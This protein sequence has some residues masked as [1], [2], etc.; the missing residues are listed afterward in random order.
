MTTQLTKQRTVPKLGRYIIDTSRSSVAFKARHVFGLLTVPGTLSIRGGTVDVAEPIEQSGVNVDI[1]ASS[2]HTGNEQ[3]DTNVRSTGLLD[4][5]RYPTMTF[6]SNHVTGDSTLEG[7]LTVRD[8][9][10]VVSL[11]IQRID[12]RPESFNVSATARV[13]RKEFGVNANR[14][15]IGRFVDVSVELHCVRA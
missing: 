13:D 1:D 2:F 10:T 11:T 8:V 3:R 4:T 6:A 14:W 12:V 9:A 7:T 15:I 5:A